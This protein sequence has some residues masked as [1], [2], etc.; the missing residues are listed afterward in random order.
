MILDTIESIEC[1]LR[2]NREALARCVMGFS[3]GKEASLLRWLVRRV[4][5]EDIPMMYASC[6]G[7]EWPSHLQFVQQ[8]GAEIVRTKHD[9]PWWA[10]NAAWAFMPTDSRN[11]NRFARQHQRGIIRRLARDRKATLLWG[12]RR[13]DGN[14]APHHQYTAPDGTSLWLPLRDLP[15][16]ALSVVPADEMSPIYDLKSC[17][18]SGYPTGRIRCPEAVRHQDIIQEM[19]RDFLRWFEPLYSA[20]FSC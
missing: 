6:P 8:S 12:N 13:K 18:K 4:L 20:R 19:D 15:T 3:G 1:H 10:A 14:W 11:A 2:E 16:A 17:S 7:V 9:R 5:G